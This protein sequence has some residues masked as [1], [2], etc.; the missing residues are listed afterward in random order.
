[1]A[2]T[3]FM[4]L[5]LP[6]V[7]VTLGPQWAEMI[8]DA[9]EVVD[10]HD[11]T[12]GKGKKIPTNGIDINAN[13]NFQNRKAFNL[14]S[15]QFQAIPSAPLTGASNANSV[16]VFNNDLYFTNGAGVAVQ[17]TSGGSVVTT[18]GQVQTLEYFAVNS[19]LTINPAST[20]VFVAVDTTSSRTITLP[21]ASSVATGRIYAIK[22]ASGLSKD[23]PITLNRQGSD[24][25]DGETS[26][27][28]DS[29][30]S[31]TWVISD[32]VLNWYRL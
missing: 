32:G 8:N 20:F 11:H 5:D 24:L 1:M 31:T 22:D 17:I 25:I 3:N 16:S 30:Y 10:E 12:S 9:M 7:L 27:I 13:L 6:G 23:N 4:N 14:F 19:N 21:L 29:E 28:L 15:T 2:I 18:P 26:Q